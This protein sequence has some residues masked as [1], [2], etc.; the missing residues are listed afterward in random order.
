MKNPNPIVKKIVFY[1]QIKLMTPLSVASGKATITDADVIRDFE[2]SPFIPASSLAGAMRAY[3]GKQK[4]ESCLLG[5]SEGE[6][7]RMSSLFLSDM[8]F[9]ILPEC[10]VRDGVELSDDK[11]AI[12][13]SKYD[14]EIIQE[15][16]IGAFYAEL[17][18]REKER[19]IEDQYKRD[20]AN[21][22]K[23]IQ[24]GEL[25]LG[26]K[27]T[28]RYG[29]IRIERL[30]AR[31][32]DKH[33]YLDY[34]AVYKASQKWDE[35]FDETKSWLMPAN[36]ESQY[37]HLQIPLRLT[38]G[39]SIR[40]YAAKKGEPDFIHMTNASQQ[41]VIPGS[42]M[43]GALRHRLRVILQQL[44]TADIKINVPGIL[45]TMFGYVDGNQSHVSMITISETTID[46]AAPLTMTRVGISRFESAARKRALYQELTYVNGELTLEVLIKKS[47][48]QDQ[49]WM[50][51]I[52]LLAIEDLRNGLLAVGG[53][54][55]IG[56]GIFQKNG[57]ITLDGQRLNVNETIARSFKQMKEKEVNA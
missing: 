22:I 10:S 6:D 51:G 12:D 43:A 28:R 29:K 32:F 34:A 37:L 2:G 42:S 56:R 38:G 48:Y 55:A 26:K 11:T 36:E 13:G 4:N 5:Y 44:H 1:I 9:N 54:T 24:S 31:E 35:L 30:A 52:L 57:E 18:I 17:T 7:G 45:D 23:G 8:K 20:F 21:I 49:E 15:G 50:L 19:E 39:I 47:V 41:A 14:M 3:L 27:K 16:A 33:N 46:K 53:E 40:Q 25:R